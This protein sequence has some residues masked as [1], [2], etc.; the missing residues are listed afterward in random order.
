MRRCSSLVGLPLTLRR[1]GDNPFTFVNGRAII[2]E[3]ARQRAVERVIENMTRKPLD[4]DG[5]DLAQMA[6]EVLLRYEDARIE[7]ADREGWLGFL[8]VRVVKMLRMPHSSFRTQVVKFREHSREI[9]EGD[10][11]S[12][13]QR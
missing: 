11:G 3:L 2:G 4:A 8:V 1:R 13:E 12:C 9:K 5:K 10:G 6:Y 7:E